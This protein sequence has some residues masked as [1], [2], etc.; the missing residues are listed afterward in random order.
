MMPFGED[1]L[2]FPDTLPA[3]TIHLDLIPH[4]LQTNFVLVMAFFAASLL[5]GLFRSTITSSH[6]H[7]DSL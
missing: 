6:T 5:V 7:K 1:L 2:A 4:W 3:V